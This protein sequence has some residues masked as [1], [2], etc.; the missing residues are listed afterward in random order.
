MLVTCKVADFRRLHE[1]LVATPGREH[2]G[3]LLIQQQRW[4]SAEL[5]RRMIKPLAPAA[6]TGGLRNRLEFISNS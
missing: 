5:A 1:E 4:G 2:A 3:I 6:A